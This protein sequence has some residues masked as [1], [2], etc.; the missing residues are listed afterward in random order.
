MLGRPPFPMPKTY[1]DLGPAP[2]LDKISQVLPSHSFTI[3]HIIVEF[4]AVGPCLAGEMCLRLW[5]CL[6]QRQIPQTARIYLW[7]SSENQGKNSSSSIKKY[8]VYIIMETTARYTN[9]PTYVSSQGVRK[10]SRNSNRNSTSRWL[11][12]VFFKYI[13]IY[14]YIHTYIYLCVF[15]L[16]QVLAHG[17]CSTSSVVPCVCGRPGRCSRR[18]PTI[19]GVSHPMPGLGSMLLN[20]NFRGGFVQFLVMLLKLHFEGWFC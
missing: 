14:T 20:H 5:R 15:V 12:V 1:A 7:L 8:N 11:W 16:L 4:E 2:K 19:A 17:T 9:K 10:P 6:C 3:C 18:Q 13:Y